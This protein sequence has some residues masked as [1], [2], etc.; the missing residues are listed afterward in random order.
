MKTVAYSE[1]RSHFKSMLDAAAKGETFKITLR[2]KPVA[3]LVPS[4]EVNN[5]YWKNTKIKRVKRPGLLKFLLAERHK[6][7]W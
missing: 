3:E 2:G 7:P 6:D 1:A 5:E 4:E